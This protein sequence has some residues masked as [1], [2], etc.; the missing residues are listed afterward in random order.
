M[1][2]YTDNKRF[3]NTVKLLF[4]NY[5]GGLQKITLV[6]DENIILNNKKLAKTSNQFF[7]E[8]VKSGNQEPGNQKTRKLD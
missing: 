1:K 6:G 3:W 2:N 4:S 7:V 8:S 5:N